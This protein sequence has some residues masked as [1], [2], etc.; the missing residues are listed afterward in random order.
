[1]SDCVSAQVL[2]AACYIE[3]LRLERELSAVSAVYDAYID[4][5]D[6]LSILA[7]QGIEQY[8]DLISGEYT[9]YFKK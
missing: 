6:Q 7:D 4:R 1:M 5:V 2:C 3:Q 8:N 9:F